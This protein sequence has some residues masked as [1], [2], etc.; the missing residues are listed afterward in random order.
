M[1]PLRQLQ[2]QG[3]AVWLDYIR[4]DI[5]LDGSL[6]RMVEED[7]VSGVTSNPAIFQKAI[8]ESDLYDRAIQEY[9]RTDTRGEVERLY[10]PPVYWHINTRP[11]E[12]DVLEVLG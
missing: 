8:G 2:A 6:Q 5:L 11:L 3:Q 10:D 7:G 9:L 12:D 4:R 1:N